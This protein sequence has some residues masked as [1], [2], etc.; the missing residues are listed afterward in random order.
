[1]SIL[2]TLTVV[3][4]LIVGFPVFLIV[5]F[6][7]FAWVD[8]RFEDSSYAKRVFREMQYERVLASDA[9][10]TLFW[11]PRPWDNCAYGVVS[12]PFNAGNAAP[13]PSRLP[14]FRERHI[15]LEEWQPTP[16]SNL[17]FNGETLFTHW[18]EPNFRKAL[19]KQMLAAAETD[20]GWYFTN[21]RSLVVYSAPLEIAFVIEDR[22]D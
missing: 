5:L 12:L 4:A 21:G 7:G 20:G 14:G 16:T 10:N 22:S 11:S 18:C 15:Y 6:L 3:A 9:G 13:A 8:M 19:F 1:M 2:R 17:R